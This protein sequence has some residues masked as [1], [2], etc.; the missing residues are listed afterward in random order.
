MV[1]GRRVSGL[2]Y[3]LS[4]DDVRQIALLVETL[5]K[6][7]LDFLEL[8]LGDT[9]L[10]IGKGEMPVVTARA[11][12]SRPTAP[13]QQ[14]PVAPA[15]VSAAAPRPVTAAD[16]AAP[17]EDDGTLVIVAPI[18]GRFYAKPDPASAP[19]VS[20]GSEVTEDTTVALIEV[21][22]VFNAVRADVRGVIAEICVRDTEIIEYG[23]VM[24][25][26]RPAE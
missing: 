16:A 25:R 11:A 3:P 24:F 14:S 21:M 22:K 19:F 1:G 6:S 2:F 20:V 8:E 10:T 5:D 17:N 13:P 4:D 7:S 9:K 23:Q 26:V 12:S 18:M 15:M